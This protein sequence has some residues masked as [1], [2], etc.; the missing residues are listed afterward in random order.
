MAVAAEISIYAGGGVGTLAVAAEISMYAGDGFET[1]AVAAEISIY[2]GG[3]A[4]DTTKDGRNIVETWQKE[5]RKMAE[6]WWK[7]GPDFGVWAWP[8]SDFPLH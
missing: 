7:F 6:T 1:V 2:A 4:G 8:L 5:N 3:R